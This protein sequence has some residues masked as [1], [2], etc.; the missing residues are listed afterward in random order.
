MEHDIPRMPIGKTFYDEQLAP[1][2]RDEVWCT[3]YGVSAGAAVTARAARVARTTRAT[4]ATRGTARAWSVGGCGPGR[5]GLAGGR[6][7]EI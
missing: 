3:I 4:R 2:R 1:A 5:S 7:N 6:S